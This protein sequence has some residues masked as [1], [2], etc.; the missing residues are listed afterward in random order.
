MWGMDK[1]GIHNKVA[2]SALGGQTD[3]DWRRPLL[4]LPMP[5][6]ST[7]GFYQCPCLA[8]TNTALPHVFVIKV[9][10]G[11]PCCLPATAP[12]HNLAPGLPHRGQHQP[13]AVQGRQ[14][15]GRAAA[16]G[17]RGGGAEGCGHLPAPT[18]RRRK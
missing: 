9:K 6:L 13:C 12:N 16:Q 7:D 2:G 14:V 11:P 15:P 3:R 5:L 1:V 18:T 17:D 10:I 4:S 8:A